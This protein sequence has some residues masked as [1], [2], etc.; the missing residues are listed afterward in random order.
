MKRH[1]L[2]LLLVSCFA[3]AAFAAADDREKWIVGKWAAEN[4]KRPLREVIFH[5]DH[6]WGVLGY[7]PDREDIR[8]RRWRIAGNTLT[9]T[10]PGDH[11]LE[12]ADYKIISFARDKFVTV[13]FTYTREK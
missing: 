13:A 8:G 7:V 9:L 12:T 5:A 3:V 6:T 2:L 1:S 4:P 11:G 10:Y